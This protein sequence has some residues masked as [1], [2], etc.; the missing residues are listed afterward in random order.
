MLGETQRG[1]E[2]LSLP[3]QGTG[4]EPGRDREDGEAGYAGVSGPLDGGR[5]GGAVMT[6]KSIF[7]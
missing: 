4:R 3:R 2:R 7:M 1:L 6:K 5:W